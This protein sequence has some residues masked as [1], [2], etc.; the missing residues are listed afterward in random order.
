MPHQ[1]SDYEAGRK[2]GGDYDQAL[3]AVQDRLAR[4]Q[5]AHI[6]HGRRSVV[7]LEGWDAAGKGGIVQRL[8]AEWDPRHFRVWPI[9]APT[10]EEKARHFLWRFWT[11]LPGK[12][13]IAVFD[14]S[15][16][17]RVLVE[18]VDGF[19]TEAQWRRAF[20]EINEFEAQQK[21]DGTVIVKLFVHIT[22]ETQDDRLRKRLVHPWK[23]WKTGA[24]DFHNRAQRPAYLEAIGDMLKLTDTRWSPW[25]LIDGN[26]KKAARIAALEAIADRLEKAVP[27]IPPEPDETLICLAK[28]EFGIDL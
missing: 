26:N 20:D 18:R 15:W 28:S 19:A 10:A 5:V 14:R 25:T 8:T 6:V 16:Y 2:Y 23:R 27:M 12:G 22:P 9:A 21:D 4:I 7:V 13:E 24:D 11:R 1:L 3:A 17:G